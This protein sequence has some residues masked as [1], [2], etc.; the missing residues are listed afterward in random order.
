MHIVTVSYLFIHPGRCHHG[1][2]QPRAGPI[3]RSLP[4]TF[5][6]QLV[7]FQ[8]RIAE[9]AGACAVMALERVPADIRK[10]GGVSR[11]V[12]IPSCVTI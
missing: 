12:P 5:F 1:C 3:H 2:H 10:E 6:T 7:S 11:M 8:A 4:L 9:E